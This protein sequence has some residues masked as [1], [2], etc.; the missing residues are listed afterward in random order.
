[1]LLKQGSS[2][3]RRTCA[4]T[5]PGTD[6]R[7]IGLYIACENGHDVTKKWTGKVECVLD[8]WSVTATVILFPCIVTAHNLPSTL[9]APSLTSFHAR[10][11]EQRGLTQESNLFGNRNSK[12]IYN[13]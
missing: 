3:A 7:V 2:L 1:M 10:W 11:L 5:L 6:R 13:P 12:L 4:N 9:P 8:N